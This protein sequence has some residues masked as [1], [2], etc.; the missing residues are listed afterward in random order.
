[1]RSLRSFEI[2]LVGMRHAW[3]SAVFGNESALSG[4]VSASLNL[5]CKTE[6]RAAFFRIIMKLAVMGKGDGV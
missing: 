2:I 3:R 6:T 4:I 1:M 5:L